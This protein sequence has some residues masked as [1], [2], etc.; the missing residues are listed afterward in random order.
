[1]QYGVLSHNFTSDI[2]VVN[3]PIESGTSRIERHLVEKGFVV[4]ATEPAVQIAVEQPYGAHSPKRLTINRSLPAF[5]PSSDLTGIS[6]DA[7]D[8]VYLPTLPSREITILVV[9]E[10]HSRFLSDPDEFLY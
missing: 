2:L 3:D 4:Y 9:A 5:V 10:E 8:P 7:F 1:M 6:D